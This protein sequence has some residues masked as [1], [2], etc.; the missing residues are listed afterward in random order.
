VHYE[1]CEREQND[2]HNVMGWRMTDDLANTRNLDSDT[3]LWDL[4]LILYYYF[5]P[6]S[7]DFKRAHQI[8]Q[9]CNQ[10]PNV[11]SPITND[12]PF[13]HN[14]LSFSLLFY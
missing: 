12:L 5:F 7:R 3:T 6:F 11:F 8:F 1:I 9:M 14:E 2:K 10:Q 4:H 13:V